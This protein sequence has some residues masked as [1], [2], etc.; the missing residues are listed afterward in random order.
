MKKPV[1]LILI[2]GILAA[3]A[4]VTVYRLRPAEVDVTR[5]DTETLAAPEVRVAKVDRGNIAQYTWMTGEILPDKKV[6][7][8]PK[9][10]GHLQA[11]QDHD[12]NRLEEGTVVEHGDVVAILDHDELKAAVA[13]A[14]ASHESALASREM[15]RIL[16]LDAEREK[17]RW[18][19]LREQGVGTEQALDQAVTTYERTE[20]ELKAADR[21]VDHTKALLEQAEVNLQ[22]A[23]INAPF[24]GIVSRKYTEKGAFVGPNTPLFRLIDIDRVKVTGGLAGKYYSLIQPGETPAMSVVDAYPEEE[25]AG[26]VT[27]IR[28]ELEPATRTAVV[29]V[30]IP[31]PELKLKPGMY[32]RMEITVRQENNAL[33]IPDAAVIETVQGVK[34][35]VV[36]ND[37]VQERSV[38]LGLREGPVYQVREGLAEDELVVIS[39]HQQIE[40]GMKVKLKIDSN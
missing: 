5:S 1:I 30:E 18:T 8:T 16:H 6:E 13:S 3:L 17:Q 22:Q 38:Q 4:A 11:L 29:T 37:T 21:N 24:T 31:N 2:I 9:I 20:A 32:A 34:V 14:E 35:Y 26:Q 7:V 28:P 40:P 10:S 25:F 39:G 19:R 27:R 36:E 12:G 33:L 15:T 23:W